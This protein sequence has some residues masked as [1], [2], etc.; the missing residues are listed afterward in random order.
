MRDV[1]ILAPRAEVPDEQAHRIARLLDAPI[2]PAPAVFGRHQVTIGPGRI[3]VRD[4][5]IGGNRFAALQAHAP[6]AAPRSTVIRSTPPT[7]AHGPALPF[8]QSDQTS[9]RVPVPPIGKCTPQRR[10]RNAIRQ[11]TEVVA[12]G[13]A[14]DQQRLEGRTTGVAHPA[15]ACRPRNTR[16][17]SPELE[18]P[19]EHAKHVGPR[20]EGDM[21]ELFEADLVDRFAGRQEPFVSSHIA[22]REP[23]HF[24]THGLRITA[25]VEA[26]AAVEPDAVTWR[27]RPQIDVVGHAPA[28]QGPQLFGAGNGG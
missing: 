18:Q 13:I 2:G 1:S 21:A 3:G 5:D 28:A 27:H 25:V 19:R 12:N 24:G 17:G 8:D 15:R 26:S 23:R 4:H 16:Y 14:S 22:R 9:T 11:Y 7:A 6:L 20:I 10:S